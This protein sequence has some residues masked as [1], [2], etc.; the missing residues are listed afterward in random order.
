VVGGV[1]GL[2][3]SNMK[4]FNLPNGVSLYG[5]LTY[6]AT[7]LSQQDPIAHPTILSGDLAG[8]DVDSGNPTAGDASGADN[9]W[10]V[11]TAGDDVTRT[12]VTAT[13]DGLQIIDGYATGPNLGAL[14]SPLIAGFSDG[15]GLYS[16]TGST[17]TVNDTLFEYNFA[18]NN[19]G[20]LYSDGSNLKVTNSRFLKNSTFG[21]LASGGA[22]YWLDT[23]Q[24]STHT[25]LVQNDLFQDNTAAVFGGA[26]VAEGSF[27]GPNSEMTILGSVFTHN[28]CPEGGAIVFDTLP[29]TIDSCAFNDNIA[30][31]NGGAI[32]TTNI[33]GT[34][35]G[36][37]NNFAT[38]ITRS[39]FTNNV[40]DG[41][42]SIHDTFFPF[43]GIS[44][45]RGGGALVCY[46][47]GFLN[48]DSC[49][50]TNNVTLEADG[51]AI[52]NGD[53][54]DNSPP[55]T[56]FAV[57]TKVT[58]SLFVDNQAPH[59]N[60]GAIASE[61]DHLV[62]GVP[63]SATSLAVSGSIFTLNSSFGNG[64]AIYLDTSTASIVN[65]LFAI[66]DGNQGDAIFGIA[67]NVNGFPSSSSAAINALKQTNLFLLNNIVLQ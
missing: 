45:A 2:T 27:Q 5:G 9:A 36:A 31:V 6:G 34:I 61:S 8:N 28:Q 43:P 35:E 39:T 46:I 30:T 44:F 56:A 48:V 26:M 49:T 3:V 32:S 55:L 15:G 40:C 16:A 24:T 38:T 13:L 53:A 14:F 63:A 50:F 52:L 33:V 67:S 58:N 10:H 21:S 17:V 64:G 65:N 62:P 19:G 37:P 25:G 66:N 11:V 12:G 42:Q 47:N 41:S 4:T 57:T 7:S 23:F 18:A 20:G 60:G 51:G 29:V 59:G 22:L 1:S 54:S